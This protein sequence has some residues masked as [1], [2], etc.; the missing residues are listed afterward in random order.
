MIEVFASFVDAVI[1]YWFISSFLNVER[2]KM[3]I[4]VAGAIFYFL[5][6]LVCDKYLPGF[7]IA[8][9]FILLVISLVYALIICRRNYV[10]AVIACCIYK[11]VIILT[12][13]VM[14]TVMSSLIKDFAI[15]MQGSGSLLRGVYLTFHK[16]IIIALFSFIL[17]LF[18]N[19]SITDILTGV[20][21]FSI[22]LVT[23]IGLGAVMIIITS[24]VTDTNT[25]VELILVAAFVLVNAGVYILVNRVRKLEKQK[26]ELKSLNDRYEMQQGKYAEAIGVWNNV[27]KV[28]HDIKHHLCIIKGQLD[29]GEIEECKKYV[30]ELIPGTDQ[31]GKIIKSDN[32]VLDYLINSKLCALENTQVI[33][34]G[35]V[36]DLSDIADSDLVSIF[37]NI[38]DNAI[39]AIKDLEEKR[40]ELLFSRHGENRLVVCKNTIGSSVLENNKSLNTSKHDRDR[41]G[42]GH[43]IVEETV[44][45][46]GGMISY[47]E[48]CGMFIVQIVLPMNG[49]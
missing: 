1:C 24:D 11:M 22:S 42:L 38:I 26:Y 19:T 30:S 48:S 18:K 4:G 49:A 3:W 16:V 37:G 39:E 35:V 27:R 40:I 25:F 23:I 46:L 32:T 10:K 28:Q 15:I 47:S 8:V 17:V 6:T 12:S 9:T 34:S 7:S 20:V 33:V 14:F 29:D 45:R 21:V 13:S 5:V 44:N 41:H 36:G 31:M 2:R 43:I